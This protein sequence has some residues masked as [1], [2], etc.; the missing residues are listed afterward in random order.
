MDAR[1]YNS[2]DIDLERLGADLV[3]VYLAQGYQAQQIGD[4]DQQLVQ[5]KKGGDFEAM[6]GMQAALS[7][8]LQRTAGGVLAM[9]GKQRWVDKAAVGAVGIV[10]F[11][12]L[13]PLTVT[14]GVGAWRQASLGNQAL[15]MVDGLVRQQRPGVQIGPVPVQIVPQIQQQWAPQQALP[16]GPQTPYYVPSNQQAPYVPPVPQSPAYVPSAQVVNASSTPVSNQLRCQHCNTPYEAGDTFCSGCGRPLTA[17][18]LYCSN[19]NTE[20]KQGVAFC[21][22]CGASTFQSQAGAANLPKPGPAPA[23]QPTYQ[24]AQP[25]YTPPPAPPKLVTPAY[26]PPPAPP[27][28]PTYTPP[29]TQNPPVQPQP[30]VYYVPSTQQSSADASAPTVSSAPQKPAETYYTPPATQTPPSQPQP[31]VTIVPQAPKQ[32]PPAPPKPRP[33]KQYYIPS[34]PAANDQTLPQQATE[35]SSAP[36]LPQAQAVRPTT[37]SVPAVGT[38]GKLTLSDGQ[39]IKLDEDAVLV[40]RYDHDVPDVKPQVDFSN[41]QGSDTISRMH[42]VLERNGSSYTLTDLNS[43]NATR[44]NGKRLEPEKATPI[45]DGDTLQFGK[46][47]CTFHKA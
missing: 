14:A 33:Q 31:K 4:K 29:V 32:E 42:A 34:N 37:Q 11:A 18:K 26:T 1:F 7:L 38:W 23:P 44:L 30:T 40:G 9:I 47:V 5:I 41:T 17:A 20:V 46:I 22:K 39:E 25:T 3:N 15:N 45:T 28:Q 6:I 2:D 19:C 24:P 12:V 27:V 35:D 8:T 43:T 10:A 36:T 16:P 21:P 13:W